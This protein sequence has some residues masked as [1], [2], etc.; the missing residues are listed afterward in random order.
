MFYI[1]PSHS[2]T[3]IFQ[4]DVGKKPNL[5]WAQC[6]TSYVSYCQLGLVAMEQ[7]KSSLHLSFCICS[8][9]HVLQTA[10]KINAVKTST[11]K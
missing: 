7:I 3:S 11:E 4:F 9:V 1:S 6:G 2:V 8:P 5:T 10:L